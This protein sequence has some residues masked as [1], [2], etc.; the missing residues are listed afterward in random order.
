MSES[1]SPRAFIEFYR[2]DLGGTSSKILIPAAIMVFCG[3]P[4]VCF[5]LAVKGSAQSHI[6][7]LAVGGTVLV[8]GLLLG[9]LG[10]A[11]LVGEDSYVAVAEDGVA[12]KT[13][14]GETFYA[15]ADLVS[16][17][18]ETRGLVLK[19][20]ALDDDV[21]HV[22]GQFG[23]MSHASLAARLEDWRRKSGWKLTPSDPPKK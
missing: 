7:A 13:K 9:F 16:V 22:E 18:S 20:S 14:T 5:G 23:G 2:Q 10:M 1:D 19:K 4:A 6:I 15:W 12:V 3:A 8:A 11:R 17:K 21:I